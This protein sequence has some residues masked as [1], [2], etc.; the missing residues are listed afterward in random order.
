[1]HHFLGF[2]IFILFE[3]RF[4][5][6]NI[7]LKWVLNLT[8][9]IHAIFIWRLH[10][11]LSSHCFNCFL[12]YLLFSIYG[13][14]IFIFIYQFLLTMFSSL[15]CKAFFRLCCLRFFSVIFPILAFSNAFTLWSF[16]LVF[17]KSNL[18]F[19]VV[20]VIWLFPLLL[21]SLS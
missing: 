16:H 17:G 13:W 15:S 9:L 18:D 8:R 2:I 5:N 11:S 3:Q 6:L 10:Y 19:S 21:A 14:A 4:V 7:I 1:V 20:F 12:W